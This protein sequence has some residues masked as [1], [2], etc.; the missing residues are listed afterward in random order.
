MGNMTKTEM[1][2]L[3]FMENKKK[4]DKLP[5]GVYN[6]NIERRTAMA[7]KTKKKPT[8]WSEIVISALVDLIVGIILII[9]DKYIG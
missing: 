1:L 3:F 9:I 5:K 7:K 4:A 8:N 2:P 6:I